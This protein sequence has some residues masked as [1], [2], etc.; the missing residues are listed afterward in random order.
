MSH[1]PNRRRMLTAGVAVV[2]FAVWFTD[3]AGAR[4]DK[5]RQARA[6]G[7]QRGGEVTWGLEAE[8]TGGYC[9]PSAQYAV[10]GIMVIN[11]IYD[12]L[13]TLNDK[14]QYVPYLAKS[15]TPNATYDEWT[16]TL[17]PG[18]KF[19]DGE[20]VDAAAVKLNLDSL[21]GVN[22][23]VQAR[24]NSF[25]FSNVADVTV[26]DPL[27]VSVKSKTP[28]PA[29]PAYLFLGGRAGIVAPGA[30]RTTPRRARPT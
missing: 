6:S 17:R 24:I 27:T 4:G 30:A 10:S 19:H 7:P 23:K 18:V 20:P 12:T 22:P 1:V 25:I 29:F 9:L 21:R 15:V 16:I 2:S 14:G 26:V 28:W 11:A 3:G 8:T 13:T 5:C